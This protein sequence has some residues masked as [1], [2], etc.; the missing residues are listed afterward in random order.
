VGSGGR[1][2]RRAGGPV[3]Q[4]S[5][6]PAE[7][8]GGYGEPVWAGEPVSLGKLAGEPVGAGGPAGRWGGGPVAGGL[9]KTGKRG[10]VG[11]WSSGPVSRWAGG[12]AGVML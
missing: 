6:G 9:V 3:G 11:G 7:W 4:W 8:A 5:R 10:P 12:A 1:V 2:G